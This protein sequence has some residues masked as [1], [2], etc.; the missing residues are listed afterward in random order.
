MVFGPILDLFHISYPRL[1]FERL[2][3]AL[4]LKRIL[5]FEHFPKIFSEMKSPRPFYPTLIS[6]IP[7]VNNIFSLHMDIMGVPNSIEFNIIRFKYWVLK[8]FVRS[9]SNTIR[10]IS[11]TAG[12]PAGP[13]LVYGPFLNCIQ[14]NPTPIMSGMCNVY[15]GHIM[16]GTW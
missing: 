16:S 11:G 14:Y 9:K 1:F 10:W 13:I 5:I 2:N 7:Y 3:E 8:K 4:K 15:T 6:N 12:Y